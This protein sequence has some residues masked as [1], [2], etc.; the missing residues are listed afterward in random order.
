MGALDVL[1]DNLLPPT[2]AKP[3]SEEALDLENLTDLD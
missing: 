3:S 2:S 1:F